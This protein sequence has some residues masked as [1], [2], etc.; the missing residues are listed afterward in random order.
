MKLRTLI[1]LFLLC[2]AVTV[3]FAQEDNRRSVRYRERVRRIKAEKQL[4]LDTI[5]ARYP[6]SNV[7][8]EKEKDLK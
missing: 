2:A 3:T 4:Y 7:I 8:P 6:I 5:S 1:T